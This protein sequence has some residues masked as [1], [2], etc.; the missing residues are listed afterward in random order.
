[1]NLFHNIATS[2][3]ETNRLLRM[4][5]SSPPTHQ[6]QSHRS[7]GD[8]RSTTF[9]PI[10]R[11]S[12]HAIR[13]QA[14]HLNDCGCVCH[15]PHFVKTPR[16]L[17]KALGF[18]FIQYSGYPF[19]VFAK[20]TEPGCQAHSRFTAQVFYYF[21]VWLLNRMI[22]IQYLLTLFNEPAVS[23]TMRAVVPSGAEIFQF[24]NTGDCIGLQRL[25]TER[26]ASPNDVDIHGGTALRVSSIFSI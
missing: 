10:I 15:R 6:P 1:M 18:L 4:G 8:G 2:Q 22:V 26:S 24:A 13:Y 20:C 16:N 23:M 11:I 17:T 19:A 21:P 14:T 5:I 7:T 12:G 9:S 3:E 25:F